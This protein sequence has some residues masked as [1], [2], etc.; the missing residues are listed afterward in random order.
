MFSSYRFP[1]KILEIQQSIVVGVSITTSQLQ[2]TCRHNVCTRRSNC[3]QKIV[4]MILIRAFSRCRYLPF[5]CVLLPA[6]CQLLIAF[7]SNSLPRPP[8]GIFNQLAQTR[9]LWLGIRC[10]LSLQPSNLAQQLQQQKQQLHIINAINSSA[11]RGSRRNSNSSNNSK[12]NTSGAS[13]FAICLLTLNYASRMLS[14]SLLLYSSR[15][16]ARLSFVWRQSVNLRFL[17][18]FFSWLLLLYHLLLLLALSLARHAH[19]SSITW[20]GLPASCLHVNTCNLSF[21]A[22]STHPPLPRPIRRLLHFLPFIPL[23]RLHTQ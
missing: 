11:H 4:A 2:S 19:T 13:V 21:N 14:P 15:P 20:L 23:Q 16:V 17:S 1:F 5:S 3:A 10:V 6:R 9:R 18:W 7:S 12:Y 22:V 8:L